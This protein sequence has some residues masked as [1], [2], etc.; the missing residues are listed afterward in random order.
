MAATRRRDRRRPPLRSA[1]SLC[2][3]RNSPT[4]LKGKR[5]DTLETHPSRY[6]YEGGSLVGRSRDAASTLFRLKPPYVWQ[7]GKERLIFEMPKRSAV[8]RVGVGDDDSVLS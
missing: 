7:Q 1:L 5:H 4:I 8:A 6:R 2:T 3:D